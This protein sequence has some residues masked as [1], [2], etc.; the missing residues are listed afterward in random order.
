MPC[1]ATGTPPAATTKAEVVEILKE[2]AP[3]PPVPTIS[4]ASRS[5]SSR[6]QWARMEAAQAVISSM[7]SPFMA[8]AVRK[9]DIWIGL[10]WPPMISSITAAA[11]S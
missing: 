3:S 2:L 1:L 8:S 4:S 9:A 7:V 11:V 10:A 6:T 5:W